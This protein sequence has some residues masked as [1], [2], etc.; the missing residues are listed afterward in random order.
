MRSISRVADVSINT[1]AKLLV[2]SG[3]ACAAF[4]DETVRDVKARRVQVDEIWSFT[5]ANQKNVATVKIACRRR[6]RYLDL[7]GYRGRD[8]TAHYLAGRWSGQRLCHRFHG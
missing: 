2:D 8:K 5:A 7:D 6:W 4:H 3:K 1:V